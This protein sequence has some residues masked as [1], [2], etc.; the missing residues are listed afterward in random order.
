MTYKQTTID[1]FLLPSKQ[2]NLK[3]ARKTSKRLVKNTMDTTSHNVLE[4]LKRTALTKSNRVSGQDIAER[5]GFDNTAMV[6]QNIKKI[7]NAPDN[8]VIIASDSKGYWI[9]TQEEADEGV[10]LMI[11]KTLSQ[12]ETVINMYPR[13]AE[14]IH[15][16]A[17][18]V[19]KKKDKAVQGQTSIQFNGWENGIMN[20]Y[21]DKYLTEGK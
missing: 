9:P 1:D 16:L 11:A 8:D 4:F 15:T 14:M 19:Y 5:F 13:S 12:V 18:W 6:R 7:R 2:D 17:G 3:R 10:A 21:A 20:K